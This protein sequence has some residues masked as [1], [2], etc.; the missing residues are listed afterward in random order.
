MS[1]CPRPPE[2]VPAILVA[3]GLLLSGCTGS[4]D[5]GG[6]R[7]GTSP[8]ASTSSDLLDAS[9][10]DPP[11][12]D[13]S[14]TTLPP[15]SY[16]FSVAANAGVEPPDAL[17]KVPSG[18]L[19]GADWY[20]VSP[21][22]DAFLGLWTVGKVQRDACLRPQHDYFTP[23][24][25]VEDLA[26]ALVAQK[27]TRA[28]APRPVTVAG[29]QGLYV[30]LA[31]PRDISKCDQDPGLWGG[32]GIYSDG[33]VDLVWILDVDGQRI[34][35]NAAHAPTSTASEREKLTSMVESL[36]FVAARADAPT[37]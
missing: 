32:R 5:S 31:S 2:V 3:L 30:E 36:K 26:D 11:Q 12:L 24:P 7:A 13:E 20:V 19:G 14:Y 22:G 1:R 10:E 15:R 28:S 37:S 17:V 35:V 9:S 23:G 21:D 6:A 4:S 34:V 33:Q 18:F 16:Q 27:S 8:S 25:S 29:H